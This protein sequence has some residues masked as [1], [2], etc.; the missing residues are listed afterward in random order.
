[1]HTCLIVSYTCLWWLQ[2]MSK[3]GVSIR[4]T[5]DVK[6]AQAHKCMHVELLDNKFLMCVYA[7]SVTTICT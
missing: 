1:M 6:H 2:V 7:S 4:I 3:S 5:H